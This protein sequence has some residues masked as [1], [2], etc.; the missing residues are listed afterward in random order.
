MV[1]AGMVYEYRP[2]SLSGWYWIS[3]FGVLLIL[4]AGW[5]IPRPEADTTGGA[6]D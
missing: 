4:I 2:T 1:S 5:L 3:L 6:S